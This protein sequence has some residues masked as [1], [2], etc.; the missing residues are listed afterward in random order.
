MPPSRG[1]QLPCGNPELLQL[2]LQWAEDARGTD[3]ERTYR[4]AADSMRA[5]PGTFSHP[6]EAKNL[7]G[8]GDKIAERLTRGYIE[9][10]EDMGK[11]PPPMV[12]YLKSHKTARKRKSSELEGVV[13]GGSGLPTLGRVPT[14]IGGDG[15]LLYDNR[16]QVLGRRDRPSKKK[17][18]TAPLGQD[19]GE[20]E[21]EHPQPA[22]KG[23]RPRATKQYVPRVR[24][25]GYAILMALSELD[26]GDRINKDELCR[27]A[28]PY[29]DSSFTLAG[30]P[31]ENYKY[32]AWASMKTLREHNLVAQKGRPAQ[33]CLTDYG[34]DIAEGMRDVEAQ[35]GGP[36][37]GASTIVTAGG[38]GRRGKASERVHS[39]HTMD[40]SA[41]SAVAAGNAFAGAGHRLS[42][43]P[44]SLEDEDDDVLEALPPVSRVQRDPQ[45]IVKTLP[46]RARVRS[47]SAQPMN[48]DLP[49]IKKP[50]TPRYLK[51][52][53]FS[54]H[55]VLDNREVASKTDRDYLQRSFENLDC[56]PITRAMELGDVMWVARGKLYENGRETDEEVELSLDYVCERKRVSDLSASIRDGR[57]HEQKFRLKKFVGNVTYLVEA[58]NGRLEG[59]TPQATDAINTATYSTQVVNG[60]FVKITRGPDDTVRYLTRFTRM[61]KRR[62]EGRDLYMYPESL[63]QVATFADLKSYLK[64]TEPDR[65]YCLSY[66]T[67]AAITSKSKTSTI[68]DIFLQMLMCTRGVTF[69]KACEIQKHF[70][71]PREL[72]ERYER[73]P[74]EI[75][76]APMMMGVVDVT[77]GTAS[78]KIK[79]PL[80]KT[81]WEVWGKK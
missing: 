72:L 65:Y 71:T 33:F 19:S 62:Y 81:I 25:G 34:W 78:K 56:S 41:A 43:A 37:A 47:A 4:R 36:Q 44:I 23:R 52:G 68:R 21:A 50:F 31:G 51:A 11:T 63:V 39:N 16:E 13:G 77:A 42:G 46:P 64:E 2:L 14:V 73:A 26:G 48:N 35:T 32:T 70:K 8:I 74:S 59:S 29:C 38:G 76:G 20:D 18:T 67:V 45:P 3:R 24:S 27:R 9:L 17:K 79:G 60:F 57:Y 28:Q 55:L 53:S 75:V 15:E 30:N 58:P 40:M 22:P 5:C 1:Q 49:D 69:E 66:S 6:S 12:P 10:M 61:L 80:S 7:I 54:I